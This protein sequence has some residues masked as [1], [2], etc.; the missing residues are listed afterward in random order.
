MTSLT[1]ALG[2]EIPLVHHDNVDFGI[3]LSDIRVRLG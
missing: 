1:Y 2:T 3:V